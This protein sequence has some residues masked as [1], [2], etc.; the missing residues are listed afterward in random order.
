M[1]NYYQDL[2]FG[3]QNCYK[4]H[5]NLTF[6]TIYKQFEVGNTLT[7]QFF[8]SGFM[9]NYYQDL[10]FGLQNCYKYHHNLTF[11]TIYKKFEVTEA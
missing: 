1:F 9:F 8:V 11:I 10:K 5:H 4:Y 6:V 3:L 7:K 2:K